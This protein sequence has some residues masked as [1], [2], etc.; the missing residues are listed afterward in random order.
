LIVGAPVLGES[1]DG[2]AEKILLKLRVLENKELVEITV[3][4]SITIEKLLDSVPRQLL[5]KFW[6][7][8]KLSQNGRTYCRCIQYRLTISRLFV[9]RVPPEK[10]VVT[11]GQ[12]SFNPLNLSINSRTSFSK[13]YNHYYKLSQV[14]HMFT[15]ITKKIAKRK[16]KNESFYD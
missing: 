4:T 5:P 9:H 14:I 12:N 11:E 8:N 7:P 10:I 16:A 1:P 2:K 3:N 13:Y 15:F 6:K